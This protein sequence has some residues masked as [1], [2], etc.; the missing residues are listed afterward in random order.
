M[1]KKY[2]KQYIKNIK[3]IDQVWDFNNTIF[4][5]SI[6]SNTSIR[7]VTGTVPFKGGKPLSCAITINSISIA[8]LVQLTISVGRS[9]KSIGIFTTI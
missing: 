6:Y 3:H 5:L 7:M 2:T 9:S 8:P 1:R 4:L